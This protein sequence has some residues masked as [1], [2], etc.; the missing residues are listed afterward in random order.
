MSLQSKFSICFNALMQRIEETL[1]E[2]KHIDQNMGQLEGN[3]SRPDV[4]FPCTLLDFTSWTFTNM[5]QNSQVAEGQVEVTL[6]FAQFTPSSN[7][8][9]G[10]YRD[11]ALE[12]YEIEHRLN[13][14]LHGWSPGDDFG[15]LTRIGTNTANKMK[16]IRIRTLIYK[17]EFEDHSAKTIS[18]TML[19]PPLETKTE[20][21]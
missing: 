20:I 8:V 17:L 12:F 14:A 7:I 1:S 16:G 6:G 5:T 11:Q 3:S 15:T 21:G 18:R 2:I 13:A 9:E 10:V 19:K 4:A